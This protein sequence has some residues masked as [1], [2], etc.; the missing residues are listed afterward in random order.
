MFSL[1]IELARNRYFPR[2]ECLSQYRKLSYAVVQTS[3]SLRST[4][5]VFRFHL[6]YFSN[7]Q[8]L[9]KPRVFLDILEPQLRLLAHQPFHQIT[10]FTRLRLRRSSPG[11][12]CVRLG[13]I[14][15]SFRSLAS[16]SPR[17]L[18][19]WNSILPLPPKAGLASHPLFLGIVGDVHAAARPVSAG[20]SGGQAR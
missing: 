13:S 11:S 17:P 5:F 14:V 18:N 6:H 2:P 8:L 12:A 19:R 15:V 20:T 7:I 10:G 1:G 3:G 4:L 16:I 9:N